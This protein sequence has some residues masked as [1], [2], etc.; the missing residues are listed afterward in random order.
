MTGD[1]EPIPPT[2]LS[3]AS[4]IRLAD[5]HRNEGLIEDAIRI[6]REGLARFPSSLRARI[7]LGQSL[8]DQ[9]AIGEAIVE[10][11]RVEREARDNPEILALL[12]DVRTAGPQ[13]TRRAAETR[14]A[15]ASRVPEPAGGTMTEPPVLFLDAFG[16]PAD[17]GPGP[18]A[19]GV[20]PLASPTLAGLYADQGDT[21]AADAIRRQIAPEAPPPS[22]K[23]VPAQEPPGYLEELRRLRE[24]AARLRKTPPR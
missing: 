6:C 1:R 10:L 11:G 17:A 21:D 24:V 13:W 23:P 18:D 5:A 9:G 12:C 22:A 15:G 14:D 16:Q 3:E 20:D 4:F 2:D 8:L 7:L 19:S